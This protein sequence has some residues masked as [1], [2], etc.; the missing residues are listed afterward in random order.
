ML[1]RSAVPY[2][3]RNNIISDTPRHY[4]RC[5]S[6]ITPLFRRY[7]RFIMM[8]SDVVIGVSRKIF[9]EAIDE[10]KEKRGT[11]PNVTYGH[12]LPLSI[13]TL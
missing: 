10:L 8:F 6:F 7:R 2:P 5:F 12:P 11:L 3:L 4:F 13:T 9:D 1:S